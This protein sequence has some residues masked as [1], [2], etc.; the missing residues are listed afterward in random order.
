MLPSSVFIQPLLQFNVKKFPHAVLDC[1]FY[2][3]DNVLCPPKQLGQWD[4]YLVNT[5][6][7][8]VIHRSTSVRA[9]HV[10]GLVATVHLAVQEKMYSLVTEWDVMGNLD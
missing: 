7:Y 3:L 5:S 6:I 4:C 8:C 9:F 1:L 2:P 10:Q